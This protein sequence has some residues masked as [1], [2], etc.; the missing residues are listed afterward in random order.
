MRGGPTFDREKV[1]FNL[2]RLRKGGEVFEIVVDP[3]AAI[4]FK[5]TGSGNLKDVFR[6]EEIFSDAKKGLI[7]SPDRL[8]SVLGC[9]DF[10]GASKKIIDEGEIQL[11]AEHREK[12][13]TA[14]LRK[15]VVKIHRNAID[16]KTGNP[17][18]EKRIEL[19]M[20]E[21]KV[22]ID[23]F[24]T[25]EQQ[26][27]EVVKKLQP[28]LPLRFEIAKLTVRI[29]SQYAAKMY[30][31]IERMAK[32]VKDSWLNDGSWEAQVELPA[33]LKLDFSDMLN[34]ATHGGATIEEKKE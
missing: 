24:R 5:E 32:I 3:D 27:D 16:P 6:A 25:V 20:D 21:A 8:T 30:G 10:D 31:E 15:L 12:V 9:N 19:A 29:P 18:P 23:E 14:K 28:I 1:S 11:T 4:A 33:G 2:A 7:A 22:K 17:H 13:R 34:G 26:L